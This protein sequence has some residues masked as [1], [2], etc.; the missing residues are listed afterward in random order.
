[1]LD[2]PA[3]PSERQ[4]LAQFQATVNGW[5]KLVGGPRMAEGNVFVR[6]ARYS[7][8]TLT[9]YSEMARLLQ[10]LNSYDAWFRT[11]AN[12][13][14]EFA[15]L[16]AEAEAAGHLTTAGEHYLRAAG[17]YHAAQ[18]N[19]M[20]DD[21]NKERGHR[22]CVE[23]YGKGA[24]HCVPPASR[25]AIPSR[26]GELPAYLRLPPARQGRVPP[27]IMLN[28]ANS[29]KEEL[30]HF[31]EHFLRRGMATLAVE[32]PGQGEMSPRYGKPP[33][34]VDAFEAAAAAV[35]DWVQTHR[36]LDADRIGLW[37]MSLGGFLALRV[38][39]AD[40]RMAAAVSLGG[41]YDFRSLPRLGPALY[42]E[43]R[44]LMGFDTF[45]ETA[46]YIRSAW[47][48]AKAVPG[49]RCPYVVIHGALDDLLTVEEAQLMVAGSPT[50]AELWL[51]EDGVHG[52]YNRN[53][54]VSPRVADWMAR[55]LGVKDPC[56]G[57]GES[58]A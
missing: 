19:L 35:I 18:I 23:L 31:S 36:D 1:M 37:G 47:S 25:V 10:R 5:L 2:R 57:Q 24:R 52:C 56:G 8:F 15:Q 9:D 48:L 14:E 22:R 53:L 6:A 58:R 41:F 55:T 45:A 27:V 50:A 20:D 4:A 39:G 26:S 3:N 54:E 28:G 40:R 17:L 21:P 51:Y 13:G 42:E 38:A 46:E 43:F 32:G 30:H 12:R 16:A 7:L 34:R 11:F 49:I 33:L 44:V 29:V